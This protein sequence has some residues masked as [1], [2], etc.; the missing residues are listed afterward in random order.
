MPRSR[1]GGTR[2][3]QP[4][5]TYSNRSDLQQGP[6][7]TAAPAPSPT[8]TMSPMSALPEMAPL[9][10][11]TAAPTEPVTAA[12]LPSPGQ[13][14]PIPQSPAMVL[15]GLAARYRDPDLDSLLRGA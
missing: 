5:A 12:V 7:Q 15:Q 14:P 6:R 1:Q 4:G 10:A 3:G 13:Q 2:V 11:P 9:D 8:T